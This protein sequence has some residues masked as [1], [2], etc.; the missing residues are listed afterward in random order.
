[1][2]KRAVA[3]LR[4]STDKQEQS[5]GDQLTAISTYAKEHGY[6]IVGSPFA[7]D[8]RSGIEAESRPAFMRMMKLIESGESDFE[9]ILC[10]DVSRWGRFLNPNEAAHWE[11]VCNRAGI[12]VVYTHSPFGLENSLPNNIS[13]DL[14]REMA[15]QHSRNLSQRVIIGMTTLAKRGFWASTAP[16]GYYRAEVNEDRIIQRTLKKGERMAIKNHH[17]ILV[18]GDQKEQEVVRKIFDMSKHGVGLHHIVDFLNSSKISPPRGKNWGLVTV[19]GILTNPAYVGTLIWGK[20]KNGKVSREDNTWHDENLSRSRHDR[21]KW[22]VVEKAFE[23]IVD[24]STF[25]L[26]QKGLKE[27]EFRSKRGAGKPFG[28][29][30]LLHRMLECESC[31]GKLVGNSNRGKNKIKT[32]YLAYRCSTQLGYGRSVCNSASIL[33]AT[34]DQYV[35]DKIKGYIYDPAFWSIVEKHIRSRLDRSSELARAEEETKRKIVDVQKR[36]SGLMV[37]LEKPEDPNWDLFHQQLDSRRRELDALQDELKSFHRKKE[38]VDSIDKTL[39]AAKKI[40]EESAVFLSDLVY[41]EFEK[42]EI[43]KKIVKQ[44]LDKGVLSPDGKK[45]VFYFRKIPLLNSDIKSIAEL[46]SNT[47]ANPIRRRTRKKPK[48]PTEEES[49]AFIVETLVLDQGIPIDDRRWFRYRAYAN[50]KK[51][52]YYLVQSLLRRGK[53]QRKLIGGRPYVSELRDG[54]PESR[55]N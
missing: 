10:F 40:F 11:Y 35:L 52:P 36:I 30:F 43:K 9:F 55:R 21:D 34:A 54:S 15:S 37:I 49:D 48:P 33:R 14:E 25:D 23:P 29:Q 28:S 42:N 8:G 3:Y 6:T 47:S 41:G 19:W 46:P 4:A 44:F 18:P 53:L 13:K 32:P 51:I 17:I 26:V 27:R 7:D 1:M 31:G 24:K 39:A 5:V 45:V 22:V 16:Y 50:Q 20:H 12:K 38:T 2:A